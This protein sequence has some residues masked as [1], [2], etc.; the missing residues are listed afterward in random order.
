MLLPRNYGI[1]C[2]EKRG[3]G[4]RGKPKRKDKKMKKITVQT[5]AQL[6]ELEK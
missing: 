2:P 6:D 4:L 5:K 3:A 1:M